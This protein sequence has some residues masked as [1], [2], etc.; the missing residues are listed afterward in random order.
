MK[1][2]N[3]II[4]EF[5]GLE[6]PRYLPSGKTILDYTDLKY[7]DSWDWIHP[8]IDKI[9]TLMPHISIPDD[10]QDLKEGTHGCEKYI[11]VISLP[12][13]TSIEEAYSEVVKFIKWY[14]QQ[15]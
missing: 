6:C 14:N 1:A 11:D 15:K 8:V 12:I 3:E 13:C 4:A 7:H 2:D 9:E 5:M 10:L